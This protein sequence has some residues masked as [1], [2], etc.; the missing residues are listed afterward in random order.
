VKNNNNTDN[1]LTDASGIASVKETHA[2][3]ETQHRKI[4]PQVEGWTESSSDWDVPP[5]NFDVTTPSPTPIV[6]QAQDVSVRYG[7]LQ[8]LNQ[9]SF[10]LYQ[11]DTLGLLGLNG[12]GKSTLLKVLAGAL[13]P[14][15]GTVHIGQHELFERT[16]AARMDIGYA[17]DI[18]AVYPE[19]RV[20]E[21]LR[22]IAR[23]RRIPRGKIKSCINNVIERCALGD[24]QKRIIGNLSSGYQQRINIA[25]ALIHTPQILI[26][27]EPTNGL[28][29]VQLMEMRELIVSLA[30][31]QATIF[32]SHLLSEVDAICNRVILVSKGTQILDTSH[33]SLVDA[34]TTAFEV[35]LE[36]NN[37]FSLKDLPGIVEA[38]K[39]SSGF[40][41]NSG[42]TDH[43]LVTGKSITTEYLKTTLN[44]RGQQIV[45]IT[46]IDNYLESLFRQ[47]AQSS[48][49]NK[50]IDQ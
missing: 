31:E 35:Q 17:P 29:P 5:H 15:T 25:Q 47:L 43:W 4:Q 41:S 3:P 42:S 33:S 26:L 38:N 9:I 14:D 30:P 37:N 19:F 21:F 48:T 44:T 28:D 16:I 46:K 2:A 20:T 13:A 23:M 39:I 45:K 50:D 24:V 32:S 12:A 7:A 1:P 10:T 18:P 34:E 6:L 27:D 11:G 8:A 36:K 40:S 49:D 22:F